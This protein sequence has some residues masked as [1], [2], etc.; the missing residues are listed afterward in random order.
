MTTT[1]DPI[2]QAVAPVVDRIGEVVASVTQPPTWYAITMKEGKDEAEVRIYEDIGTFG[3][4]AKRFS[5]DIERL[6]VSKLHVRLN[7]YGGEAFDGIAI[8]N[9]LRAHPADIIIHVDGI[10]ASSGSIIAMSGDEIHM[11]E[12]AFLMIHDARGGV[13]GE[14]EDMRKYAEVLDKLND[15]IAST[16]Q[17][18]AG[19]SRK[20]WRDKMA[21][22][23]W[24]TAKEA[25]EEG[26]ADSITER[27]TAAKNRF[28]FKAYNHLEHVPE[29]VLQAWGKQQTQAPEASER[30]DPPP[31]VTQQEKPT[32][33][34]TVPQA[35]PAPTPAAG[36]T[37]QVPQ[38][39]LNVNQLR[40]MSAD[41]W[42]E[43]GRQ[44]GITEGETKA[45]DR[46]KAIMFVCPGKPEMALTAFLG[47]QSPE[48]AK[49]AFDATAAAEA[50]AKEVADAKD[51]EI[52]RL[53]ALI[54]TGG[55][56]EGIPLGA[57]EE[58]GND[59]GEEIAD[60]KAHA[61]REWD[62]K[63]SVRKGFTSKERYVAWR[64][65]DIQGNTSMA[66]A[67]STDDDDSE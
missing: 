16:Y 49:L 45:M 2:A 34:D 55:Y 20:Y 58:A 38:G 23:S 33:A 60:P 17:V 53:N 27:E 61:E 1:N 62:Y 8:H 7:T 51:R 29:T 65:R 28:D 59:E 10:A 5:D 4:S 52:A 22:E 43:K 11:A 12:N 39:E 57:M 67:T 48:S 14:A 35:A 25:K 19:K 3:V 32:M 44:K 31:A 50:K 26:L 54:A 37:P 30:S 66:V 21:E 42:H 46:L 41:G 24:F 18:R 64:V 13:F 6:K 63:P 47:G 9:A 56:N 40:Q 36:T 15:T